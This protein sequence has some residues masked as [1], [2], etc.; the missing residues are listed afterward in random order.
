MDGG[1]LSG[2]VVDPGSVAPHCGCD[3]VAGAVRVPDDAGASL[4]GGGANAPGEPAEGVA[5]GGAVATAAGFRGWLSTVDVGSLSDRERVDLVACLEGV[6]GAASAA[7][8]RATDA[9]RCSREVVAP[10]DVGRSVGSVVALARRESPSLGDRFVGL[11]RALVHEMPHTMTALSDGVCSERVAGRPRISSSAR[12]TS[13]IQSRSATTRWRSYW[14]LPT[15][16]WISTLASP[17]PRNWQRCFRPV[18]LLS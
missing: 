3:G 11:A 14:L 16:G 6:K 13:A 9:L 1:S 5:D 17:A 18:R 4:G 10:Q 8:A 2:R 7:Q 15:S 12:A